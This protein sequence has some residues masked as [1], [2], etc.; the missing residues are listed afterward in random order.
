MSHDDNEKHDS[1][2][3]SETTGQGYP[4]EQQ[5]GMGIDAHDHAEDDVTPDDDAPQSGS[6]RDSES[7]KATGNPKA[8]GG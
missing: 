4:E 7:S 5:P 1:P 3:G 2:G 8:A 6:G